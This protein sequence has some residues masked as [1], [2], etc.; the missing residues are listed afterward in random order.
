MGVSNQHS[1]KDK[2]MPPITDEQAKKIHAHTRKHPSVLAL[3]KSIAD[4]RAKEEGRGQATEVEV[5]VGLYYYIFGNE[6]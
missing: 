2:D 1:T 3:V 4:W 6:E 5:A